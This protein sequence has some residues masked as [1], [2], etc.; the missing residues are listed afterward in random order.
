[1][2][3]VDDESHETVFPG[4]Y[5]VSKCCQEIEMPT[6]MTWKGGDIMGH[7]EN[8][9]R[10]LITRS[11]IQMNSHKRCRSPRAPTLDFSDPS[12]AAVYCV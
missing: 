3:S 12:I 7:L 1:M 8:P 5:S 4:F 9:G 2:P 6:L 10:P 11:M